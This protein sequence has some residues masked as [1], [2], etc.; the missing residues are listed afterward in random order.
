[1]PGDCVIGIIKDLEER[2]IRRYLE[3][4]VGDTIESIE[5]GY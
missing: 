3:L 1:M 4:K 5:N 2:K